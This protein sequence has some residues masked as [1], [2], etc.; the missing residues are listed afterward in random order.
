[1]FREKINLIL[2]AG[3]I[4]LGSCTDIE[5]T[6]KKD[7]LVDFQV[8][9]EVSSFRLDISDSLFRARNLLLVDNI[10]VVKDE[11]LIFSYKL[12]D[13]AQDRF[14]K[15]FGKIGQGPCE[16]DDF[17]TLNRSGDTGQ[18]LGIFQMQSGKF[19]E[20]IVSELVVSD[21]NPECVPLTDRFDTGFRDVLRV[22]ENTF[23]ATSFGE[24]PFVLLKGKEIVQSIGEYPFQDQFNELNPMTLALANQSKLYKNPT[25]PLILNSSYSSFNMEILELDLEGKLTIKKT[26]HFWPTEFVDSSSGPGF[27]VTLNREN[28]FGNI[29][30]SVSNR[31]IYVLYND[32]PWEYQLPL[33]S[34]RVLV[35][36]WEGKSVK[37]LKLDREIS[38]IA[39]HESDSYLI[40]YVDDGKANLFRFEVE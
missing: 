24:N 30:T 14:L 17:N 8:S 3:V 2:L 22:A 36:D 35:Y 10:L 9:Y 31:Y 27:G 29:S 16:I 32:K 13:V 37:I 7:P 34:N 18:I 21:E 4:S 15:R 28:R 12:V 25:E 39:I 38:Q 1:M 33:K 26:M 20:F 40:G 19:Q 23:V 6:E 11:D 5:N